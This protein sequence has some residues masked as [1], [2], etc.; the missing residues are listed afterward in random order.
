[1]QRK[2]QDASELTLTSFANAWKVVGV[3]AFMPL[4]ILLF[5]FVYKL[6]SNYQRSAPEHIHIGGFCFELR[7]SALDVGKIE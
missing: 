6:N 7:L 5:C 4:K 2:M 1:M 3:G